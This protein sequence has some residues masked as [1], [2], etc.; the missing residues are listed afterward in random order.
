MANP[1][2]DPLYGAVPFS[3]AAYAANNQAAQPFPL[4]QFIATRNMPDATAVHAAF[5]MP[6]QTGLHGAH[7]R[8]FKPQGAQVSV[9]YEAGL[10]RLF[11][12]FSVYAQHVGVETH[13]FRFASAAPDNVKFY[14]QQQQNLT[15]NQNAQVI[16]RRER[17]FSRLVELF[18]TTIP[19]VTLAWN[20][21]FAGH[22][23]QAQ[24]R[25]I[26]TM[27]NNAFV[28]FRMYNQAGNVRDPQVN[29]MTYLG[30]FITPMMTVG[31]LSVDSVLNNLDDLVQS[32]DVWEINSNTVFVFTLIR[33]R[34]GVMRANRFRQGGMRKIKF[35]GDIST[36]RS[37]VSMRRDS[38]CAA[39][40]LVFL[41]EREWGTKESF[42]K[43][44]RFALA[45]QRIQALAL[46]A[47]SGVPVKVSGVCF[48]DLEKFSD[49]LDIQVYVVDKYTIWD[50]D[51]CYVTGVDRDRKVALWYE[52]PDAEPDA[53]TGVCTGHFD[54]LTKVTKIFNC[55]RYCFDCRTPYDIR[56]EHSCE[57][58]VCNICKGIKVRYFRNDEILP[59]TSVGRFFLRAMVWANA[60]SRVLGSRC[61]LSLSL[62][63]FWCF[64]FIEGTGI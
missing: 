34:G 56:R 13:Y 61:F 64:C 43:V 37:I 36:V 32:G 5:N 31:D 50:R 16:E 33:P 54:A 44:S 9:A 28:Q 55:D 39:R 22:G 51:F 62:R 8:L 12:Q 63:S 18:Q 45:Q 14:T 58:E 7:Y 30:G 24:Q 27:D 3:G 19:V 23:A 47:E 2:V 53:I 46:H 17:V 21:V 40:S 1:N 52:D 35:S 20:T 41:V 10:F 15:A 38:L 48:E 49:V 25:R 57:R 29:A 42:Q 26:P 11:H 4:A 59:D 6:N 60:I